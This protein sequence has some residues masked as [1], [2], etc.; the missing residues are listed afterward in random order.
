MIYTYIVRTIEWVLQISY[1]KWHRSIESRWARYCNIKCEHKTSL[2]MPK[3]RKI[4]ESKKKQ[5]D[6]WSSR[7][8]MTAQ[9]AGIIVPKLLTMVMTLGNMN[10]VELFTESYIFWSMTY[11]GNSYSCYNDCVPLSFLKKKPYEIGP[12]SGHTSS[13]HKQRILVSYL[14]VAR[15]IRSLTH[16]KNVQA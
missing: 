9:M 2:S 14:F 16:V 15:C 13:P 4:H 8:V 6:I 12:P 1:W 3:E 11:A 7:G 5:S 10:N